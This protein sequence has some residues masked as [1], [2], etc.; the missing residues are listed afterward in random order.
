MRKE[1]KIL[2]CCL[3]VLVMLTPVASASYYYSRSEE[4]VN[5]SALSTDGNMGNYNTRNVVQ[6]VEVQGEKVVLFNTGFEEDWIA[7]PDDPYYKVPGDGWDVEGICLYSNFLLPSLTHYWSQFDASMY[8]LPASGSYCAGLW[9]SDG[10]V[11]ENIQDEWLI[12]PEIDLTIWDA[13]LTFYSIYTMKRLWA[14]NPNQHDY[15]KISVDGGDWE[16]LADLVHDDEYDFDECQGGPAGPGWN[17]NEVPIVINLSG[18]TGHVIRLAWHYYWN[19][20]IYGPAGCWM[21]D[22]VSITGEKVKNVEIKDIRFKRLSIVITLE[23]ISGIID[24]EDILVTITI[25]NLNSNRTK[26]IERPPITIPIGETREVE[27]VWLG[28]GHYNVTIAIKGWQEDK[29]SKDIWWFLI[30]GFAGGK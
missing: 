23:E 20:L 13:I 30:F 5:G 22:D 2:V 14:E 27:A 25:Q 1:L 16:L 26:I 6:G 7:D 8:P 17:F 21:I 9:W 29:I 24:A 11:G 19:Q 12:T 3:I 10:S 4:I 15:V 18:Y 28:L